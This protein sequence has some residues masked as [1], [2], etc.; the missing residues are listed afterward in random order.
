M[1]GISTFVYLSR[2]LHVD[3]RFEVRGSPC[4]AV[5]SRQAMRGETVV[6]HSALGMLPSDL[7]GTR[8]WGW[9]AKMAGCM[10]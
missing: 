4:W 5:A 8:G 10:E 7:E 3:P 6:V 9:L 2:G 1:V